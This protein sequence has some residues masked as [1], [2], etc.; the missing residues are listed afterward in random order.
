MKTISYTFRYFCSNGKHTSIFYNFVITNITKSTET[1]Y[2]SNITSICNENNKL[3]SRIIDDFLAFI[4][5]NTFYQGM[6]NWV[7]S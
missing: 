7:L 5:S 6:I 3:K 4:T 1:G 2:I